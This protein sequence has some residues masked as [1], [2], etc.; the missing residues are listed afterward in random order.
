M[1]KWLDDLIVLIVVTVLCWFVAIII[2]DLYS[3]KCD[4]KT[5]RCSVE[6]FDNVAVVWYNGY[7]EI[8]YFL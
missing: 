5:L 4:G 1:K 3:I 7:S 8:L 6:G 2:A